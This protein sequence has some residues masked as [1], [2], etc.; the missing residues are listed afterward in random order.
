ML[1]KAK[2]VEIGDSQFL[3]GEQ[4]EKAIVM[5]INDKLV[6]EGK[7]PAV[8]EP[9]LLGITKASLTTE[10]FIS[11][12]SFQETTRVLTNASVNGKIDRLRGLKENVIVGRLIPA[13]T[14]LAFHEDRKRSRLE[15]IQKNQELEDLLSSSGEEN[16]ELSEILVEEARAATAAE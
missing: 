4:T 6:E 14:G 13:G 10:S 11:A 8:F 7:S 15:D 9:V 16:E 3:P 12:A 2:I 1:R 5:D